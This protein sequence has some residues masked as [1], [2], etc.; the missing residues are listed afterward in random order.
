[1]RVIRDLLTLKACRRSQSVFI[2]ELRCERRNLWMESPG[3]FEKESP[4]RGN[5][6]V[7]PKQMF[8]GRFFRSFRMTP[9]ER[10]VQL[11]RITEQHET[12]RRLRDGKN[13]R[14]RHLARFINEQNIYR[15]KEL[16]T[17]P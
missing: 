11:L 4:V 5:G 16:V 2:E 3:L 8:Q 10:L 15:L 12:L 7:S 13:V 9:F 17:G 1:M 6:F 14:E